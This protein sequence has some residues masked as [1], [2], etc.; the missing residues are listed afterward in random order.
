LG[1]SLSALGA[2]LFLIFFVLT[3]YPD[4]KTYRLVGPMAVAGGT[5]A[6]LLVA[7]QFFILKRICRLCLAA[8]ASWIFL[9]AIELG[10]PA[11][12]TA[13]PSRPIARWA[14]VSLVVAAAL[15]PFLIASV[16]SRSSAPPE[17]KRTWLQGKIN[18]IEITDFTCPYC[19][20]THDALEQL[21]HRFADP[22]HFVRFVAAT[23]ENNVANIAARA[24]HCAVRQGAGEKMAN[25]LFATENHSHENARHLA[26]VCGLDL[27]RFD[28]DWNDPAIDQQLRSDW[29]WIKNQHVDGLPQVWIQHA[30]LFGEAT[31]D[32]LLAAARRVG[33]WQ[34]DE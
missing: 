23:P 21:R 12:K 25:A 1:I 24:Y 9:A 34:V 8:D 18:V 16:H 22:I 14:W 28:A 17:V 29:E 4:K 32:H 30:L 26:L 10:F 33:P 20:R 3:L 27:S 13:L 7:I 15:G 6:L 5:I 11:A 19:K 31:L 2:A